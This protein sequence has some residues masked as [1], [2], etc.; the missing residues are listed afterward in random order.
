MPPKKTKCN[1]VAAPQKVEFVDKP[2][3]A[4]ECEKCG[5][6]A[7][8]AQ[9]TNPCAHLLCEK[10]V[11]KVTKKCPVCSAA[12]DST[13][14]D[15]RTRRLVSNMAVRCPNA[16]YMCIWV[17]A[18]KSLAGHECNKKPMPCQF[19]AYGCSVIL[20]RE[21]M[22]DHIEK[23]AAQH[24]GFL[25]EEC[26]QLTQSNAQLKASNANLQGRVGTLEEK[27]QS[28]LSVDCKSS[29][30]FDISGRELLDIRNNGHAIS[31]SFVLWGTWRITITPEC[32]LILLV[33]NSTPRRKIDGSVDY[34]SFAGK[35]HTV[36]FKNKFTP[37][38]RIDKK[39]PEPEPYAGA[40]VCGFGV[41]V[42][43]STVT[44]V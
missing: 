38:M 26:R 24:L 2:T 9:T 25:E 13:Q 20:P 40:D 28:R 37:L 6:V 14:A 21:S 34:I 15:L 10:C 44:S 18:L 30:W 12:M 8:S 17:G 41:R 22:P 3:S 29:Q 43:F 1:E 19:A 42:T 11:P 39:L 5:G 4:T 36:P 32:L 23:Y 27:L 31:R 33:G 35:M 7:T 16:A